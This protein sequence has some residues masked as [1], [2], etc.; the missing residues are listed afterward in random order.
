VEEKERNKHTKAETGLEGRNK[1][2]RRCSKTNQTPGVPNRW[3]RKNEGGGKEKNKQGKE[4]KKE[5][6]N[7]KIR[8]SASEVY[9]E[10]KKGQRWVTR[11]P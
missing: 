11:P 3:S 8:A 7:T 9:T 10:D 5:K 1:K 2:P 6:H 4:V